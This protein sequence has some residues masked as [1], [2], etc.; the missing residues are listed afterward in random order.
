M[1]AGEAMLKLPFVLA[2]VAGLAANAPVVPIPSAPPAKQE[3]TTQ[4][5]RGN[6][7]SS[8][9][10]VKANCDHGCG[11][12]EDPGYINKLANDPIAGFTLVL[13]V[14]TV[15]L[16]FATVKA[17]NA[18]ESAANIAQRTLTELERPYLVIMDF[19]WVPLERLKV[20]GLDPGIRYFVTN[21]GK[22]PAIIKSVKM[23]FAFDGS[24]PTDLEE[25][26]PI[27]DLL[28][29][30]LVSPDRPR[31]VSQKF[32]VEDDPSTET[33]QLKNGEEARVPTSL[34]LGQMV[35]KITIEYDG[36]ITGA[37]SGYETTA[38]WE[39]HSGKGAFS[40]FGGAQHNR[41]I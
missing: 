40:Q 19:N 33:F 8:P 12:A 27:N 15:V 11:Y 14:F 10:Y 41:R 3:R 16:A 25:Q 6:S 26:P 29:A 23:G 5:Q 20:G 31:E 2:V 37:N 38:C 28:T 18:A 22:L 34:I 4:E 13:A 30:P 1:R 36:P 32:T 39:W 7:P 17:A 21:A 9:L 24:I 35:V